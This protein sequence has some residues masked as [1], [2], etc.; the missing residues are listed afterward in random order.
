MREVYETFGL[1]SKAAYQ[2]LMYMEKYEQGYAAQI[3]KTFEMS[4]S[5]TQNQLQK[6]TANFLTILSRLFY[7]SVTTS[8]TTLSAS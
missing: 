1:G 4:L 5:Q 8:R 3:A 7:G 6:F 2:V